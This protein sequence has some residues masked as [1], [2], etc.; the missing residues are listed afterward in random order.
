MEESKISNYH[1]YL[2]A[3]AN[4]A[5]QQPKMYVALS[6]NS[7]EQAL[8]T[9]LGIADGIKARIGAAEPRFRRKLDLD[10]QRMIS[11]GKEE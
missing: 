10:I 3:F 11:A 2:I 8:A 6:E 1:L 9:T 4:A 7:D 5:T